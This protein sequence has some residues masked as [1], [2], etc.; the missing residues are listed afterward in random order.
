MTYPFKMAAVLALTLAGCGGNVVV[1]G[2]GSAG[3]VGGAGGVSSGG[4][5]GVGGA[6]GFSS[7]GIAGV[8][9]AGGGIDTGGAGGGGPLTNVLIT[10]SLDPHGPCVTN[11]AD[12]P[13]GA[14]FMLVASAPI[15]CA[16]TLPAAM[17]AVYEAPTFPCLID[18]PFTWEV[19]FAIPP[20]FAAPG[21]Y[22]L[23]FPSIN[24]EE[25]D[26]GGCAQPSCCGGGQ[27][28][29]GGELVYTS[30]QLTVTSADASQ[31]SFTLEGTNVM[32]SGAGGLVTSDGEYTAPI[33]P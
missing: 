2:S 23:A 3:G 24:P 17:A 14:L 6:G 7:A 25:M 16:Q 15:S 30:G 18:G 29:A 22:S 9:G 11:A 28:C 20:S 19:C 1:D 12:N 10:R 27:C 33:C 8:G 4:T 31:M 21:T 5:A 32:R 13:P 26:V